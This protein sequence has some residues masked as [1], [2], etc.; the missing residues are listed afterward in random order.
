MADDLNA[1]LQANRSSSV[2]DAIAHPATVNPLAGMTSA[3]QTAGNIFDARAKQGQGLWGQALQ[4]ATDAN[5]NVDYAKANAIAAQMGPAA[6]Q[7]AAVNLSNNA[8]L[9]T[10]QIN[11]IAGHLKLVG[12]SAITV[13]QDPSDANVNASFDNLIANGSPRDQV[14]RERARWLGMSPAE[15]QQNAYR[16]GQTSL[17]QLHQV[18]GQTQGVNTGGQ[19]QPVTVTQPTPGRP[20][21]IATGPGGVNLTA[22]PDAVVSLPDV[23]V[24]ATQA[25]VQAGTATEPGQEIYISGAEAKRRQD[26]GL[27]PPNAILGTR[28]A[29]TTGGVVNSDGT[30]ASPTSPPRL[31]VTPPAQSTTQPPQTVPP[32][33][34]GATTAATPPAS[35]PNYNTGIGAVLS[36]PQAA[37]AAP[38]PLPPPSPPP[39]PPVAATTAAPAPATTTA[40]PPPPDP[41]AAQKAQAKATGQEVPIPGGQGLVAKPDGVNIGPPNRDSMM[42]RPRAALQGGV[43]VASANALL[44]PNVT[45]PAPPGAP[46]ALVPGDVAAITAGINRARATPTSGTQQAV[47]GSGSFAAGPGYDEQVNATTSQERLATDSKLAASYAANVFPYTQALAG[48]GRGMTTAPGS[49]FLN[50]AKGFA[51]GVL[52]S[53]GVNTPLSDDAASYDAQ[54]KWLS[55]IITGNP[56]A[57]GSDARLAATLAGNANTGIHELAGADMMKAGIGLMRMTAAARAEWDDPQVRAKYGYYNDFLR[58]FNKTVDPR[59]FAWDMYNPEQK[60]TLIDDLNAHRSDPTYAKKLQDSLALVRRNGYLGETRAM[61]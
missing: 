2:L 22:S 20:G 32:A 35:S 54:H 39:A 13:A 14:E 1:L 40:P 19:I 17:E 57:Q 15:R 9:Q 48:Y 42:P 27:L 11:N 3:A 61:P 47:G 46:N 50:A 21:G 52:R 56:V 10:S 53:V 55:Q 37:P 59:A 44:M 8:Q 24:K 34:P 43:P 58:D 5:G 51:G 26:S 45:S 30:K 28:P 18:I 49:D 41:F 4:Q 31:N 29:A 25:D 36:G 38:L 6:A 23:R 60:K 16:V 33:P 12:T 7:A